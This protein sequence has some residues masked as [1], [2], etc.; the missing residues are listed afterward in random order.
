MP[1]RRLVTTSAAECEGAHTKMRWFPLEAKTSRM[2]FSMVFVLPVPAGPV[3]SMGG[4]IVSTDG[5]NVRKQT[6]FT[7][8]ACFSLRSSYLKLVAACRTGASLGKMPSHSRASHLCGS[9]C[10]CIHPSPADTVPT[11]HSRLVFDSLLCCSVT[12]CCCCCCCCCFCC[13]VSSY[14]GARHS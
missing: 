8:V 2:L 3:R 11:T 13:D 14:I 4:R 7:N 9:L 10:C 5:Y 12:C 6:I 1:P